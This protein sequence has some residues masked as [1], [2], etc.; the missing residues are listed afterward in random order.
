MKELGKKIKNLTIELTEVYSVVG[1][2]EE[3]DVSNKVHE[4]FSEMKYF[5]DHPDQLSFVKTKDDIIDRK[6]VLAYIKGEKNAS[7]KTVVLIG[8]TDTVGISDYGQIQEYAT[9]P[10]ELTEKLKSLTLPQDARNDLE[11]GEYLFG[12]GI[13]DMKCG[14]ATLMAIME[15]ISK[16][17]KNFEGNIVF[18]AVCDEEGNSN[19]MLSVIPE[20]ISLKEREGFQYQALIDTDYMA[21]R[22]DGDNSRYVYIGT[23][24]KLMPSFYIVGSEAH[25]GDPFRGLDPNH[26]SS[27]I[28]DEIDFSTKYSDEAEGEVT[29]PPISL[30]Q[31]DL[32]PEYSVQTAGTSYLYFNYGT[33]NSTPDE[34]LER[35]MAGA[36][37]AFQKV[38]DNL[39]SEYEIHCNS[40]GYPYKELAW[41]PRVISYDDLYAKVKAERGQEVDRLIKKLNDELLE[42]KTIDDRL[43]ALKMV[44]MVYSLWS[45]KDPVVISYFS[46]PYYPHIYVKGETD[47][48]KNLL[49]TVNDVIKNTE[50]KY[51][52]QM[53]KFYP[54]ISDLSYGAAP[55]EANAIDCLKN[56]MP[57]FGSKYKLPI[58]DMKALNLPVVNIGPFGKDAH[59]FTERLEEDYSFN[60]APKLVYD[61]IINL[62]K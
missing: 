40:N 39:N 25:A 3:N 8:H 57:G 60:I 37:L 12:R 26:I 5:K 2:I 54:Y 35:V 62:L 41:A 28:V 52:I 24:G 58:E 51:D 4:K 20:L 23:V 42:D 22:Y 14:V 45:D 10:L 33:H 56:N 31:Q 36:N 47:L 11:S 59:K 13:F 15:D 7:D 29:V 34:V 27:A 1:T 43:F 32:K 48:E 53:K 6:S 50:S 17:I 30:R 61:T 38:I 16:D 44:E 9:Q 49:N 19:G 21:P 18:A 55:R 46:P